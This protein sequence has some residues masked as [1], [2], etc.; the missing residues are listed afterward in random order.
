MKYL[1]EVLKVPV[2][3]AGQRYSAGEEIEMDESH[4]NKS[5][6][7]V[8]GEV[9]EGPLSLNE[10][11][12][13]QLKDYAADQG[14]DLGDAKKRDEILAVIQKFE[15]VDQEDQIPPSE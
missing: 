6:V 14:I 1:V 13:N 8:I 3:Y 5:L 7:K 15:E 4:V 10:M 2:R 12:V 9:D 11:K